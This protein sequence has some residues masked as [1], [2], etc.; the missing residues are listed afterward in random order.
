MTQD[1]KQ[2][3]LET[4]AA[5]EANAAF[6]DARIGE[7]NDFVNVLIWPATQRLLELQPGERVLDAGCGNGLYARKLA[8]L[9]AHVVA[10]DFS[11]EL[12]ALARARAVDAE[13]AGSIQYH[14]LDGTDEAALLALGEGSFDAAI[15]QM[16][17]FDMAEIAPLMRAVA[18]LLKPGG[19]FI[20]SVTHP[21]FNNNHSVHFAEQEDCD[22]VIVTTYGVKITGYLSA[23]MVRGAAIRNQPQAQLYFHRPLQ[24]LLGAAFDAGFV[25][26]ALVEPGFPPEH[27]SGREGLSW[28]GNFSE[29][30]PVLVARTR[31][32]R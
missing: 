8:A 23:D 19:R 4:H 5:W 2:A 10:F 30:P 22:G 7:G 31:V 20:F 9:G 26:D 16:A 11:A 3:H 25:L 13:R 1:L 12:I 15:C 17:L 6:W 14:V 24:T 32:G 18:R 21:C 29:I 28:G 27:G